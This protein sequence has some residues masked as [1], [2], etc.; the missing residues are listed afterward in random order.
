MARKTAILHVGPQVV[1]LSQTGL[2][3]PGVTPAR[4]FHAALD[5][6]RT[7]K[8]H[9]LRRRQVDGA[10]AEVCRAAKRCRSDVLISQPYFAEAAPEQAAL[11]LD[12][13]A[14]FKVYVVLTPTDAGAV[15]GLDTWAALVRP[16]RLHVVPVGEGDQTVQWGCQASSSAVR[17]TTAFGSLPSAS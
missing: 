14:A 13:L 11:A 12:M 3:V 7:H 10:W 4:M 2:A 17:E 1:E 16:E 5:I 6:R 8:E 15:T 9:G